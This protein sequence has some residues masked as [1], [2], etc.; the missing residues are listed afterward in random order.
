MFLECTALS[1]YLSTP[2]VRHKGLVYSVCSIN[3]CERNDELFFFFFKDFFIFGCDGSLLL[4]KGF[5]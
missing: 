1:F 2:G 5:L 4:C 3:V